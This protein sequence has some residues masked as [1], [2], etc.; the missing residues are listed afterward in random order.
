MRK[1]FR[2]APSRTG[3]TRSRHVLGVLLLSVALVAPKVSLAVAAVIG[4]SAQS[5]IICIGTGLSRV[6]LTADGS[7]VDPA[8][9]SDQSPSVPCVLPDENMATLARAWQRLEFPRLY[10][11]GSTTPSPITSTPRAVRPATSSRAPPA[12]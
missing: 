4:Q 9:A 3:G 10:G 12:T 6:S 2:A 8:E 11:V 5:V 7:I 1:G